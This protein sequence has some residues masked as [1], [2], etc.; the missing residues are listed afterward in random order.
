MI[1][2]EDSCWLAIKARELALRDADKLGDDATDRPI[3]PE[4]P[5]RLLKLMSVL[6]GTPAWLLI[7]EEPGSISKSRTLTLTITE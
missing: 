4:K 3:V 2:L 5:P 6:P 1:R 7:K